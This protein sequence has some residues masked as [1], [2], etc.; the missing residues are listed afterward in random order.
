MPVLTPVG[1]DTLVNTNTADGQISPRVVKLAGDRYMVVWVGGVTLPVVSVGGTF[2]G[3]YANA[4]IRAQI[5]NADGTPFGTEI[6]INTTTA[7]AQLRPAVTQLS[8]GNVLISWH[9]GVGPAGGPAETAMNTIRAQE[10]S[11]SGVA[12]G[13]EFVLGN[14]NGRAHSVAAMA[15]GGFVATFQEGGVGGAVPAGNVVARVFDSGNVQTG[16]FVV[17]TPATVTNATFT[18]VESDGDI[19]VYHFDRD[20][21]LNIIAWRFSRFDSTGNLLSSN[22]LAS[23]VTIAGLITLATGGH[24]YVASATQGA[25]NPINIYAVMYS[26]DGNL[27]RYIELAQV[28][29]LLAAPTI[30]PLANGGFLATWNVDSDAGTGV[31]IEIMARSYNAVGNPMGEAFQVNSIGTGN[32]SGGSFV[33]LT[34]GDIV[35][36]WIDDSQQNGDTSGTGI[37]MRRINYEPANQNPTATD[38][39]FSLYG[40]AP[41]E[42]ATEDPY[43]IDG[44]F[45]P[46][47]YDA[48][49]DPLVISAVSN[50][51]NGTVTLNPD[52]TLTMTT[53]PGATGRLSFDYTISD[54]QGGTA[55]ARATV[56][57]PSDFLTIRPGEISLIDFLANDYY[58]PSG[59]ATAFTV[60]PPSPLMGG[61]QQGTTTMQ[62][63]VGGQRI[64]YDPLGFGTNAVAA[65]N[66]S[67]FDLL[68]GQSAQVVFFYNN[69]EHN[70]DVLATLEGWAQLGGAGADNLVGSNRS[71]H[72]SGGSGAAN[73]MTGGAGN[74]W[75]TVAAAGD[76]IVELSGEGTDSVRV[77]MA[78]Y[79]LAANVENLHMIGSYASIRQ[80]TGNDQNNYMTSFSQAASLMGL[81]G[82]DILVGSTQNDVLDGGE[83]NDTVSGNGGID[84]LAGGAGD[85]RLYLG[86]NASGSAVSGGDGV[87]TLYLTFGST[88]LGTIS[89]IEALNFSNNANL[90]LTG[91]QVANGLALNTV[92]SGTGT[93]TVN[94]APF[95][96][97][98]VTGYTV[99]GGSSVTMTVNGSSGVDVV[100]AALGVANFIYGNADGDQIRGGNLADVIDGGSGNDKIMGLGG[101]DVLTGG[102]G[103]DQFRY[104]FATDSGMGASA[105]R[106]VDFAIGQDLLNFVLLDADA[107]TADDQAF[108]FI[109]TAAF[110]NSGIG[111]IRYLTSGADLIVQA[112][113]DGNGVADMEI[114]LQGQGGNT[115]TAGDFFL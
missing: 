109:G 53:S 93:I 96:A 63:T 5:Y 100:K 25:G 101:A 55:T 87:D 103:N 17:D 3:S 112:D 27:E 89:G 37:N 77:N 99:T 75:Y 16:S 13:T 42:T 52:G 66:S 36:A 69:N 43:Y 78:S 45:G 111:Q 114:I 68:V 72:L 23:S 84:N 19:V 65:L 67:Y 97:V 49:G 8:D 70:G 7:G 2:A 62:S 58:T 40:V 82:N 59:G 107:A 39:T 15:S 26:A 56:T 108:S 110:T 24:A 79:T 1:T 34:N 76:S 95:E 46:N 98:F 28:P 104:Y 22:F 48:D 54:G 83:G 9:D 20:P 14:S 105:D 57:L 21:A 90:V 73:I 41:G 94:T 115:L 80:G 106:I 113:T 12:T 6:I 33:Q 35:G 10:F 102:S 4:D 81:G 38:F 51:T 91:A 85:D 32:Q 30:A 92:L 61:T 71:D 64:L 44:F 86:F 88:S 31:N 74:D 11:A 18:T 60:T 47:G 29:T 50:V